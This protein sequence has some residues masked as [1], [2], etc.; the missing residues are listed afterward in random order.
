MKELEKLLVKKQNENVVHAALTWYL[1][2]QRRGTHSTKTRAEVRG[3]GIKPWKQ[4]GTGRARAG[5]IRS[6][7]WRK[8][9]VTFGPK[10]RNYGYSFP[11]KMRKLAI[12]TAL[13]DK[14]KG[15]KI[16]IVD[17]LKLSEAKTK[18]AAKLL[19]DLAVSGK[20]LFLLGKENEI[21]VKASRNLKGVKSLNAKEINIYELLLADWVVIEKSA[22]PVLEEGL[23]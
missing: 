11:K 5:S 20:V 13:S 16:K 10:P 15:K 6:P 22:V 1:A 21:F 2:S 7:L 19:K 9:G 8:G 17:E 4:K 14:V 23:N 3:G 18:A 12:R